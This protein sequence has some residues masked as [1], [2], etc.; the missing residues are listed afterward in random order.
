MLLQDEHISTLTSLYLLLRLLHVVDHKALVNSIGASL[1]RTDR[2][3]PL[4]HRQLQNSECSP[5]QLGEG[6]NFVRE[7]T[8]AGTEPDD[9]TGVTSSSEALDGRLVLPLNTL[10]FCK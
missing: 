2:A 9:P 7:A 4:D 3:V 5:V 1:L 6:G 8:E 10:A